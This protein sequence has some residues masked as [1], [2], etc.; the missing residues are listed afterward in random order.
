MS[1]ENFKP[2]S[3]QKARIFRKT[4]GYEQGCGLGGLANF[5]PDSY[6]DAPYIEKLTPKHENRIFSE[7]KNE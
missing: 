5:W 1:L 7:S 2:F 6:S 3:E 4:K